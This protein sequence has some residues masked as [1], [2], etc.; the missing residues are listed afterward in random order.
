V[1]IKVFIDAYGRVG[2]CEKF[3]DTEEYDAPNELNAM[4]DELVCEDFYGDTYT[5][6]KPGFYIATMVIAT[7]LGVF[8]PEDDKAY[9]QIDDLVPFE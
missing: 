2:V 1:K 5:N 9:M 3:P 7:E 8:S 4:L 6:L